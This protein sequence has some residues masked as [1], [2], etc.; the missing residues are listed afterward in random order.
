[1]PASTPP[2]IGV[3]VLSQGTRPEE[4]DRALTDLLAQQDVSLD[5]VCIGNGWDPVG[6]PAPV[7]AK[8]LPENLGIPAGRNI[9]AE[10]VSGDLVAFSDDDAWIADEHLLAK[11][12]ALFAADP[13]LGA[14]CPR[15]SAPSGATL[16]RWVP[17]VIVGDPT[18]PSRVT[19]VQ[20]GLVVMRRE[21][22]EAADRWPSRF[23]YGH[24]GIEIGWR[25][26]DTGWTVYYA[27][28]LTIYHPATNWERHPEAHRVTARNRVW[29]ARRNLPWPLVPG[30]LAT[31]SALSSARLV[32]DPRSL[33]AW[34]RG[35]VEGW[36]TDAGRRRP[37]R[38]R[39]VWRLL[40]M[41]H[42]PLI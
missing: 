27:G 15:I 16:R 41:G 1:M 10:L 37:M 36:R 32:R 18:R 24:E 40:R 28:D 22:F 14:V 31:W 25:L 39:T 9:G 5:V 11:I 7:R 34:W 35:F 4:L 6:L 2:L 3:V 30:Y 12:A 38:W 33:L 17:R 13:K 23:F 20:E 42:P 29:V 19:R 8:A 21:A 26:I